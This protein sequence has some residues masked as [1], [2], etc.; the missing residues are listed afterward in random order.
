MVAFFDDSYDSN[1][2]NEHIYN[3]RQVY[4][5]QII[6]QIEITSFYEH[7]ERRN[8]YSSECLIYIQASESFS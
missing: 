3:L 4:I 7:S 5:S 1:N 2:N 8:R 6:Y